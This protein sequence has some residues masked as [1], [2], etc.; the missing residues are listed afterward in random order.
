[1]KIVYWVATSLIA[2][3]LLMAVTYLL[4][5]KEVIEGFTKVGYP[6]HLRI[7]LGIAKPLAGIVLLLPGL[8]RHKEWAYAGVTY[9]WIM[10]TIANKEAGL[11]EWFLPPILLVL[12]LV[13]YVT[14][15]ASRRV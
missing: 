8:P 13:S 3:S 12:L 10:A 9:A 11:P 2:A 15:P 14:R 1:M 5:G 6:Q 4:G 7:A